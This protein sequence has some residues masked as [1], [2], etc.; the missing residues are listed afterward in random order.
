MRLINII[1]IMGSRGIKTGRGRTT[2]VN[3]VIGG[4]EGTTGG[5]GGGG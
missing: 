3:S 2:S 4:L 5:G 1:R